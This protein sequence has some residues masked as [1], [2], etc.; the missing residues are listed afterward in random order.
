MKKIQLTRNIKLAVGLLLVF[1]FVMFTCKKPALSADDVVI[2]AEGKKELLS[3]KTSC[4]GKTRVLFVMYENG[5]AIWRS[6]RS[7]TG[8]LISKLSGD[9]QLKLTHLADN[10]IWDKHYSLVDGFDF[11]S[12]I[13]NYG[14]R[15]SSVYG[16]LP[17]TSNPF[18][19]AIY[20][21]TSWLEALSNSSNHKGKASNV[22]SLP[23]KFM[24]LYNCLTS[25]DQANAKPWLPTATCLS[26]SSI[27]P[28]IGPTWEIGPRPRNLVPLPAGL[29]AIES[30]DISPYDQAL[31]NRTLRYY[32]YL[33][34]DEK[35]VTRQRFANQRDVHYSRILDSNIY[36]KQ[37][38]Q[39]LEISRMSNLFNGFNS[40][41]VAGQNCGFRLDLDPELNEPNLLEFSKA[42]ARQN[43]E[44]A[45]K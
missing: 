28:P 10:V 33:S 29:P 14:N 24:E 37:I 27:E 44:N 1:L 41:S 5:R 20:Y 36:K 40:V 4:W 22:F 30:G 21:S 42:T 45:E 26:V 7:P 43:N 39:L 19:T 2:G 15:A 8:F 31:L 32:T 3:L 12:D 23:A 38:L 17:N 11:P 34:E 18:L 9:E 13:I 25:F 16:G 6:D 35:K